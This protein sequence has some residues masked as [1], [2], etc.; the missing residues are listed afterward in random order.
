MRY[1]LV[2][3]AH[4]LCLNG[5]ACTVGSARAVFFLFG[6]GGAF[7]MAANQPTVDAVPPDEGVARHGIHTSEW[8]PKGLAL[9][10]YWWLAA[11]VIHFKANVDARKN[12]G[13]KG[14]IVF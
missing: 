3:S 7:T 5:A 8:G 2:S 4:G 9:S 14:W 12:E 6:R 11:D 1:L 10:G 13:K